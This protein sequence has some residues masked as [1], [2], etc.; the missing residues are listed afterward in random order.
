MCCEIKKKEFNENPDKYHKVAEKDI[1]V[2]KI[3]CWKNKGF[4][5]YYCDT[6]IY[7][8]NIPN[9]EIKLV[10]NNRAC[11]NIFY[12]DEG[13]HSYSGECFVELFNKDV[14]FVGVFSI[15]SILKKP[16]VKKK[17]IIYFDKI[18]FIHE[19]IDDSFIIGKF[20][21]PKGTE[22]YKNEVGEIV[23]S[24]IIWTGEYIPL[25]KLETVEED[26]GV[27]MLKDINFSI[28]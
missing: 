13:Y 20:I 19:H 1:E 14:N 21:I 10:M 15:G 11:L 8:P 6:F 28:D 2:Y 4:S 3:G 16:K 27:I 7:K 26:S 23:S 5:P 9:K 17:N 24:N 25:N 12:I 22:Y 18:Y